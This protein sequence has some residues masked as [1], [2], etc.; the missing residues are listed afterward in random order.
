MREPW[1]VMPDSATALSRC[2][3][4]TTL[5]M[6]ACSAGVPKARPSPPT[7]A[8]ASTCHGSTTPAKVIAAS[9]S[10]AATPSASEAIAISRRS[11][12]SA[13]APPIGPA[14]V[15]WIMPANVTAPTH[16]PWPVSSY[17]SQ[18]RASSIVQNEAEA[19]KAL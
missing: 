4:G 1:R 5:G 17:T 11:A 16:A 12:R 7:T 15:I 10:A 14:S 6:I 13:I 2:S 9:D 3:A 19:K 8:K 18:P